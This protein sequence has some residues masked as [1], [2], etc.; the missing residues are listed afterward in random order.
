MTWIW[1]VGPP[2][3]GLV[4]ALTDW[5][6]RR[7][8]VEIERWRKQADHPEVKRDESSVYRSKEA[9]RPRAKPRRVT[10]MPGA[11]TRMLQTTGGGSGGNPLDYF[12]LVPKLAYV[13]VMGAD[14][15]QG[16]EHQ[17][18]VARLDDPSPTFTVRPLPII[19][20]ERA[21]NDGIQFKKD[22]DFMALF[23]V[24]RGLEG[25]PL[26]ADEA[27]DKEIRK[28]LSPP[29]RAALLELP[30][31]WLRIDGKAK[32]MALSLYGLADAERMDELLAAADIVFAEYGADGGPSLLGEDDEDQADEE[33]AAVV[34]P[35]PVKPKSGKPK[36][37]KPKTGKLK[38]DKPKGAARTG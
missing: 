12:Q 30:E 37:G 24:E 36:P 35:P 29:L 28:W 33:D 22:P 10:S 9:A 11:L 21:P 15:L 38:T 32:V 18:V 34:T 17:T 2:V 16:S 20:G 1:F 14:A 31:A 19:E 5:R 6:D 7:R 26:P 23:L 8:E 13:A 4:Y 3:V 25:A 27:I